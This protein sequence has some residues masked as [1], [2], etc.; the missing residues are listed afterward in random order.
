MYSLK[1]GTDADR[2]ISA[3]SSAVSS[4]RITTHIHRLVHTIHLHK[5]KTYIQDIQLQ[6]NAEIFMLYDRCM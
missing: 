4:V 1:G 5:N 6:N 3:A 2:L